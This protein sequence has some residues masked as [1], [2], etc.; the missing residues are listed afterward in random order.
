MS[1]VQA[2]MCASTPFACLRSSIPSV[3]IRQFPSDV[4][5]IIWT[6]H[7]WCLSKLLPLV[8]PRDTQL[9]GNVVS[10]KYEYDFVN[11]REC[12]SSMNVSVEIWR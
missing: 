12:R 6:I 4:Q 2:S 8:S 10:P 11:Y 5:K 3:L 1:L 7:R 9:N